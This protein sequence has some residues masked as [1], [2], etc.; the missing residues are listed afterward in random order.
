MVEGV[1][2]ARAHIEDAKEIRLG[3]VVALFT[4]LADGVSMHN[5]VV[6]LSR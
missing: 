2:L 3:K 6:S 5:A 4:R 1:G